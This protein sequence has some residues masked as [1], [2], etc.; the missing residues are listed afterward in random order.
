MLEALRLT[1]EFL[2]DI[3]LMT[4]QFQSYF[5]FLA[6]IFSV[7]WMKIETSDSANGILSS[8]NYSI[9]VMSYSSMSLFSIT[10]YLV[11]L[12]SMFI[13]ET[14]YPILLFSSLF[15]AFTCKS[16]FFQLFF[17]IYCCS[18]NPCI[19]FECNFDQFAVVWP[20]FLL[21]RPKLLLF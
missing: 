21:S 4:L 17:S 6:S 10:T 18:S 7:I 5:A 19:M 2:G 12:V 1:S 14:T 20:I 15:L 3:L 13:S 8:K 16:M 11:S 9:A